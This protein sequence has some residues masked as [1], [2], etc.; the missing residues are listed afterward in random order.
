MKRGT[1]T[2]STLRKYS[3]KITIL[4]LTFNMFYFCREG[5]TNNKKYLCMYYYGKYKM[6]GYFVTSL[7][8][9]KSVIIPR[10]LPNVK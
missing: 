9:D 2:G 5:N 6:E 3:N 1:H 10:Y 7:N 4:L 8:Y